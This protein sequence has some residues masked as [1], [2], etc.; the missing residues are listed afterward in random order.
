MFGGAFFQKEE[1]RRVKTL[2]A[3]YVLYGIK[4][5]IEDRLWY[6]IGFGLGFDKISVLNHYDL[7]GEIVPTDDFYIN[8]R[9]GS[10]RYPVF[11]FHL[12][13]GYNF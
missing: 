3:G 2:N 8:Q 5:T 4:Q 1:V 6:D 10:T 12:A 13:I 9:D 11:L 7:D